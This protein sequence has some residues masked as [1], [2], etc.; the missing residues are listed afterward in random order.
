MSDWNQPTVLPTHVGVTSRLSVGPRMRFACGTAGGTSVATW[1]AANDAVFA[2]IRFP[3]S[4]PVQRVYWINGSS[5]SGSGHVD[6]GL[7]TRGGTRIFSIGSTLMSGASSVQYAALSTPVLVTP[8]IYYLAY[9]NDGTTS[10]V[11]G[12]STSTNPR[13]AGCFIQASAFPLPASATFAQ[14]P[15]TL[16]VPL[17]GVT[18]TASGF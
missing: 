14:S 1:M 5:G 15:S 6:M 2:P 17:M 10:R 11:S 16:V 3:Y 8:G 18:R 13:S 12:F 4:Y 7:Y 9:A